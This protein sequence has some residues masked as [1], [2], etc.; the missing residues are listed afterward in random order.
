MATPKKKTSKKLGIEVGDSGTEILNGLV[1]E[2][3]NTKLRDTLGIKIYDEMR[4]SDGTVSAAV[5]AL[6]LPIRRAKWFVEAST[7]EPED[8]KIREFVD[9]ALFDFMTITWNDLLRQALLSLPF[10]VMPFEKVFE[11]RNWD[12]RDY[13]T[14]RKLAPRLPKSIESWQ[15]DDGSAGIRQRKQDGTLAQ[16]PLDKLVIFINDKEGDNWW[17]TSVLRPAY[18]HWFI[19]NTFYRI[20]AIAFE[21]QGL[22]VPYVKLPENATEADRSK[23]KEILQN[24]RA[25]HQAF[26]IEP[27][28]YEIGFKDMMAKTL[29][30]PKE[31]IGHHNR[32]ITKSVL[33]QFL[34]LG[35]GDTGSR[36]LSTDQTD[37]FLLALNAVAGNIADVFN[38]YAIKELVDLNFDGVEEY[39]ELKYT[40]IDRTDAEKLA[41]AYSTLVTSGGIKADLVTDEQYLR[42]LLGLPE[43][44]QSEDEEMPEPVIPKPAEDEPTDDETLEEVDMS[45]FAKT[46]KKKVYPERKEIVQKIKASVASLSAPQAIL[47]LKQSIALIA[48]NKSE[49]HKQFF[50]MVK[51]EMTNELMQVRRKNFAETND[52]K[53]DNTAFRRP[54]TFAEKKVDFEAMQRE[55]DRLEETYKQE[56]IDLLE[57]ERE[58]YVKKVSVALAKGDSDAVRKAT[59]SAQ[60]AYAKIIKDSMKSAYEYGKNNVATEIGVTVPAN[61]KALLKQ[62]DIQANALA[63]QHLAVLTGESKTKLVESLNKGENALQSLAIADLAISQK[64]AEIA[65]N[66]SEIIMAGY[67]NHGRNTVITAFKDKI[68]ALQRSEI[69]DTVTCNY[70]LSMDGRIVEKDDPFAKNT[71]FHSGCR[72]IWVAILLEEPELPAIGG[73]PKSLRDRFGDAVNDLI[74]PKTAQTKSQLARK[75]TERRAKRNQK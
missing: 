57:V 49:E 38:K 74:Q 2:E 21:R 15:L 4:K 16:I 12:G 60:K 70:C 39:P 62:I 3:Y 68:Y 34:E 46:I 27:Q 11:I 10:G 44:D 67:V 23:A 41:N 13:V 37:L 65:R 45:E 63:D 51:A 72:G 61:D 71:I 6:S 20:D 24:L 22:G 52:F 58:K 25:N 19:K 54:L 66:T 35:S 1:S 36:A 14:W 5:S 73:I 48:V 30:D 40:G 75:E 28:D 18:K 9:K 55:L 43:R 56:V 53:T 64:I 29:R 17:G 33:A 59:M 69:L 26:I 7:N 50:S 8:E 42:E 47:K 31:S 32:E